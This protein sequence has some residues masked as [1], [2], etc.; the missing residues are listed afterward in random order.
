MA[1][2]LSFVTIIA[3]LLIQNRAPANTPEA[4]TVAASDSD[5]YWASF[6]KY[7]IVFIIVIDVII[8]H[9]VSHGPCVDLYAP[10]T[11]VLVADHLTN[12]TMCILKFNI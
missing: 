7:V 12:G 3:L 4:I 6:S 9:F 10:G 5:D 1:S 11:N 2:N 8:N